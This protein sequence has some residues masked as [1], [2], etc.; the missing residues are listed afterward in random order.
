MITKLPEWYRLASLTP[1]KVETLEQRSV[2][3]GKL[4]KNKKYE[5]LLNCIRLFLGIPVAGNELNEELV[6]GFLEG[7][8]LFPQTQNQLELRI[9]AGAIV[10]EY[11]MNTKNKDRIPVA[12]SL[13]TATFGLQEKKL[14]NTDIIEDVENFLA[15][16]SIS[17]REQTKKEAQTISFEAATDSTAVKLSSANDQLK[18]LIAFLNE[19]LIK[20][21]EVLEEESNIH[22]WLFRRFSNDK[23]ES[24]EKLDYKSAPLIISKELA[25]LTTLIPGPVNA[26]QLLAKMLLENSGEE[27]EFS[28]KD[29][30]NELDRVYREKLMSNND[31]NKS[32][33]TTPL[34]HA[35]AKSIEVTDKTS[36]VSA[37]ENSSA[38]KAAMKVKRSE[39][40]LQFY[41]ECLLQKIT[42]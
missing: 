28:I 4:I 3:I 18:I 29:S 8:P 23:G 39:I 22:W 26:E 35:I 38:I 14:I 27:K 25:D 30:I 15:L 31:N 13:K 6:K 1:P 21:I 12:L 36:W 34:V 11:V 19:S 37:F 33:N 10:H 16:K 41:Y 24:I 40:A 2:D 5:W 9:L 20:R 42:K 7:D 17:I 32:G